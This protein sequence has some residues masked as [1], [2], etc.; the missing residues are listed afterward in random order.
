M[1]DHRRDRARWYTA[2]MKT[3]LSRSET[4]ARLRAL[5]ARGV[6]ITASWLEAND[7]VLARSARLYFESLAAARR[8]VNAPQP[9]RWR[10]WTRVR[11]ADELRRLHAQGH[12]MTAAAL[13]ELG[14]GE[15]V[16]AIDYHFRGISH[17]RRAAGVP[18]PVP[19]RRWSGERWD[20]SRV[21]DEILE[22]REAGERLAMTKVPSNLLRAAL[23]YHGT[24]ANAIEAAGLDYDQIR[25]TR[26]PPSEEDMIARLR[27]LARER[28]SMGWAELHA[29]GG[30]SSMIRLFGSVPAAVRA[31]GIAGWPVSK[32]RRWNRVRVLDAFRMHA[33][34]AASRIP[35]LVDAAVMY[36]GSIRAAR[37]AAKVP[38]LRTEWSRERVIRELRAA[39]ARGYYGKDTNIES[40]CVRYFGSVSAARRAAGAERPLKWTRERVIDELRRLVRDGELQISTMLSSAA[41]PLFGSLAAAIRAAGIDELVKRWPRARIL[42]LL[43]EQ[44]PRLDG[45]IDGRRV[46]K[47]LRSACLHVFGSM[48]AALEAAAPAAQARTPR[49]PSRRR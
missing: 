12:R 14:R 8:A 7:P 34:E 29:H 39:A 48:E 47:L 25:E 23:R 32:H 19:L 41:H 27:K 26:P 17:A 42:R 40:A 46:P 21:V 33:G 24:W 9:Q 37:E 10:K 1:L 4:L 3:R 35:G 22:R 16:S 5:A 49:P 13:R 15:V 28:P 30:G 38:Q 2:P 31:A 44:P 18:E 6:G 45:G 43:R 20:A 11:I 36:F